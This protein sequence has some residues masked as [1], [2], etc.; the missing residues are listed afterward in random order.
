MD[1]SIKKH[2]SGGFSARLEEKLTDKARK[3]KKKK[4]KV[5]KVRDAEGKMI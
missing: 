2:G 4:K 1:I 3:K 5:L